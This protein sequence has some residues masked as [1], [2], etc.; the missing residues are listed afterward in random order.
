MLDEP[1]NHLDIDSRQA[2]IQALTA[3]SGAVLL[4]SHDP[5]LVNACADSLWMVNDGTCKPY[6]GDLETYKTLLMAQRRAERKANKPSKKAK[7]GDNVKKLSKKEERKARA[8]AREK[9]TETRKLINRL[10]SD[11]ESL[12]KEK[13]LY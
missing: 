13:A 4:V 1:T 11:I 5:H 12:R 2:L 9:T 10:E 8:V 6:D 3:Y 7:D